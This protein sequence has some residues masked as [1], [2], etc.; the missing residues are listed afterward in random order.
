MERIQTI[1]SADDIIQERADATD[2]GRVKGTIT[3]DHV[4]FGYG[5]DAPV[6]LPRKLPTQTSSLAACRILS[7]SGR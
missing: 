5:D 3:F 6:S 4:A 1:L 7:S 2:R